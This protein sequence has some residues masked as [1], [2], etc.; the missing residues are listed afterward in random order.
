QSLHGAVF[1]EGAVENGE[2]H[3]DAGM[4][5]RFGQDGTG[6]PLALL[7][8]EVLDFLVLFRVQPGED[9]LCRTDRDFMLAGAAAVNHGYSYFHR[10]RFPNPDMIS[11]TA[12]SAVR[13]RSSITGFT[14][15]TSMETMCRE[16]QIISNAKCAS[17]YVAPPRTGVPTPGASTGSQ[18]SM[19][20]DRWSPA[21]PSVAM[22]MASSMT[23]RRPR[24]SISR[25]VKARMPE[26]R[27]C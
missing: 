19:S 8:D 15:T 10:M 9:R 17:R 27:T 6:A 23:V 21:V 4:S 7:I 13:L 11:S 5:A 18:K 20:S 25:M 2:D 26:S 16:S 12:K 3:V 1:A 14:S 24:S 22:A